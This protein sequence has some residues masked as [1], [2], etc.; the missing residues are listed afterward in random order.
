MNIT[1][2]NLNLLKALDALMRTRSV[3]KAADL[4]FITQPAMSNL[5]TQLREVFQDEILVRRRR[6]MIPT[7]KALQME[8]AVRDILYQ[9][10][11]LLSG[12]EKFE[13][14]TS[15]RSFTIAAN[16]YIEY[17]LLSK[18]INAVEKA[19]PNVTLK[20]IP[21]DDID[22]RSI[23]E[24]KGI[25]LAI[26][27]SR[28]P[29]AQLLQSLLFTDD[30]VIAV[31]K[32]HPLFEGKNKMTMKQYLMAKHMVLL[33]SHLQSHSLTDQAL[34]KLGVKRE[35]KVQLMQILP[36]LQ[37]LQHSNLIATIPRSVAKMALDTFN[38][39]TLELPFKI[40]AMPV[41]MLWHKMHDYD[42]GHQWLRDIILHSSTH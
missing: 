33:P 31:R 12:P 6:E 29:D 23:Y 34:R 26:G 20:I 27:N 25:D 19:A 9:T 15:N 36:G 10:E 39:K 7:A 18:I 11:K 21:I 14:S 5:L 32:D 13:P 40:E 41:L 17:V 38:L 24:E 2:M 37:V 16:D 4:L 28:N 22:A 1:T 35:V 8:K 30:S 3:S 42:P